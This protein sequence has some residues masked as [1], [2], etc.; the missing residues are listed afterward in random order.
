[1][2]TIEIVEKPVMEMSKDELEV[3]ATA[4]GIEID[5]RRK[6]ED[7]QKQ[8]LDATGLKK[9]AVADQSAVAIKGPVKKT[10]LKH[11]INGMIFHWTQFL[12]DRKDLIPCDVDGN[13]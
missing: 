1:M 3:F 5:K 6:L 2:E 10:H 4:K 7:L 12:A 13:E 8:V 9:S 11:P